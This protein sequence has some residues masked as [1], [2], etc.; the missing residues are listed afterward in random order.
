MSMTDP[1]AD[2]LTRIRNGNKAKFEKVVLPSSK[3]KV[4]LVE[5]LK[6][7][8]YITDYEVVADEYQ[9]KIEISLKYAPNKQSVICGLKRISK[10]GL[11]IYV[12]KDDIP[13]VLNGIGISILS[14]SNGL[15]TDR[16]AR[17]KGLGGEV[18]CKVW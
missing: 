6:Q 13:K 2:L 1:I 8:G 10:P 15:L 17:K 9:G 5:I 18:L 14:T 12:G 3:V 4:N 7:E 16:N 11:R